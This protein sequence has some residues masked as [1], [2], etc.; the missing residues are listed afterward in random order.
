MLHQISFPLQRAELLGAISLRYKLSDGACIDW[1]TPRQ[2]WS[3]LGGQIAET[4]LAL[5]M[6]EKEAFE[7]L[8]N[9]VKACSIPTLWSKVIDCSAKVNSY[10]QS[11]R[12][13]ARLL[14]ELDVAISFAKLAAELNFVRPTLMDE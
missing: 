6:A 13:N 8:R 5:T 1:L 2:E 10:A 12:R 3:R 7:T 14:H 4:T 9:E 11:L